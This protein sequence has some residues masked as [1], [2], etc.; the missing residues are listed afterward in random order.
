MTVTNANSKFQ[1]KQIN[2]FASSWGVLHELYVKNFM[3]DYVFVLYVQNL[4]RFT[5][6]VFFYL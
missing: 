1:V 5:D 6:K 3:S 2:I 4:P